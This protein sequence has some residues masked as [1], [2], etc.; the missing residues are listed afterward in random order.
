MSQED[1]KVHWT[2]TGM[3]VNLGLWGQWFKE[4]FPRVAGG[5]ADRPQ[6]PGDGPGNRR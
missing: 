5:P 4:G 2:R 3:T 6:E 1:R